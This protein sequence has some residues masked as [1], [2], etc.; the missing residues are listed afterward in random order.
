[1]NQEKHN[2]HR[3][4]H[5]RSAKADSAAS[6]AAGGHSGRVLLVE[7]QESNRM[8][9]S[10]LLETMGLEVSTAENGQ[11]AIVKALDESFDIIL[12]D[13]KLPIMNGYQATRTLRQ[14]QLKTPV[15]ALSA[16]VMSEQDRQRITNDFNGYLV[17]PVDREKLY[18]TLKRFIPD[19]ELNNGQGE[20]S[21]TAKESDDAYSFEIELS[22]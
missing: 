7:D 18:Q 19:L 16:G 1:L 15:V 20:K 12:M 11:Q 3:D 9:I 6:P 21:P 8:V 5:P 4:S 17:K 22:E 2:E 13:L 10:L 14:G